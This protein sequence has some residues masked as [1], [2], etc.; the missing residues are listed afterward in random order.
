MEDTSVLSLG[1]LRNAVCIE[2]T[3]W[4]KKLSG[5]NIAVYICISVETSVERVLDRG[6][7][8]SLGS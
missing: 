6:V 5:H 4:R 1:R 7:L 8:W 2:L 3:T